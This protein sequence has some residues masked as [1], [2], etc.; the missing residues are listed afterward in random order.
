MGYLI[1]M[2][3]LLLSLPCTAKWFQG[4]ASIEVSKLNFEET[5]AQAIK[6]AVANATVTSGSFIHIEE[7]S[8]DGL[9]SSSKTSLQ[10]FGNIRRVEIL[11]EQLESDRFTVVVNVDVVQIETCEEAKYKKSVLVTLLPIKKLSQASY[12]QVYNLGQHITQRLSL[13]M[14]NQANL[15]VVGTTEQPLVLNQI[16]QASHSGDHWQ[17]GAQYLHQRHD[18]QL[19]LFGYIRDISLFS[20][21]KAGLILDGVKTRR[22]FTIDLVLYDAVEQQVL[23]N[24]SYHSEAD[25]P[26]PDNYRA[27]LNN[28]LFWRGD[29]GRV[30]INTLQSIAE[31]MQSEAVCLPMYARVVE[32]DSQHVYVSVNKAQGVNEADIFNLIKRREFSTSSQG[33]SRYFLNKVSGGLLSATRVN[34]QLTQLSSVSGKLNADSTLGDFVTPVITSR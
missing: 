10:S 25:W 30:V 19:I 18:A 29:F 32:Q 33:S 15:H 12:G 1:G 14:A 24:R 11:S 16:N 27:D 2:L 6:I 28:S 31:Q 20:Q 9:L 26:Y 17:Q 21:E 23:V 5:R 34:H 7:I 8:L 13:L 4:Q 22:N 3:L